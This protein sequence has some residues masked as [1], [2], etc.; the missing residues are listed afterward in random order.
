MSSSSQLSPALVEAVRP[1]AVNWCMSFGDADWEMLCWEEAV[2]CSLDIPSK[3]SIRPI[4]RDPLAVEMAFGILLL[5]NRY[6][7]KRKVE[8]CLRVDDEMLVSKNN[9]LQYSRFLLNFFS[10]LSENFEIE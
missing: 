8:A 2:P 5:C 1:E 4:G 3:A 6:F 7:W 9:E 10:S